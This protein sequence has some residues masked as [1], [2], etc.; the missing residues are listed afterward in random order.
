MIQCYQPAKQTCHVLTITVINL[1]V[2]ENQILV[3]YDLFVEVLSLVC[4]DLVLLVNTCT[5]TLK[6]DYSDRV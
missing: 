1:K 6:S 2:F 3:S 5:N 4:L